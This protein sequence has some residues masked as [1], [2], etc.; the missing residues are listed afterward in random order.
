MATLGVEAA[1]VLDSGLQLFYPSLKA[2]HERVMRLLDRG[3]VME[4]HFGWPCV[5]VRGCCLFSLFVLVVGAVLWRAVLW[6]AYD[7]ARSVCVAL[8][9]WLV[10]VVGRWPLVVWLLVVFVVR[11]LLPTRVLACRAL[12]MT[13]V[14]VACVRVPCGVVDPMCNTNDDLGDR[15]LTTLTT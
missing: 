7:P 14:W 3:G 5:T 4:V 15:R 10:F 13:V 2:R 8:Q 11:L 9:R 6:R 1:E 12:S